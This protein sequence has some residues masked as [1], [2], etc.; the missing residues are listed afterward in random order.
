MRRSLLT[1]L[2][3]AAIAGWIS[4]GERA[5]G[6]APAGSDWV[7]TNDG[8]ESRLVLQPREESTLPVIHPG[9]LAAVQ[10]GVSLLFLLAFPSRVREL[11]V[12]RATAYFTERRRGGDRRQH[13]DRRQAFETATAG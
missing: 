13:V 4:A 7:R 5:A 1:I 9:V 2:I 8:W 10:L 3:V 6:L 11:A 12:S